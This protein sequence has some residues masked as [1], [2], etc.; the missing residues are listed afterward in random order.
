M[1]A[2]NS[3]CD[4]LLRN[5]VLQLEFVTPEFQTSRNYVS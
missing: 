1:Q 2:G 5:S 4:A 3:K